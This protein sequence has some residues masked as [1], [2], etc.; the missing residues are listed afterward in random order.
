MLALTRR[1]SF[2]VIAALVI[3]LAG[4]AGAAAAK[5]GQC[6]VAPDH[7]CWPAVTQAMSLP[8]ALFH[9]CVEPAEV[10]PVVALVIHPLLKVPLASPPA[11]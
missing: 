4:V 9:G 6:T 3:A 10:R 7:H 5:P 11:V 2:I 8:V 1:R